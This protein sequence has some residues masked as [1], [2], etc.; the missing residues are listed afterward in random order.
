MTELEARLT[1]IADACRRDD[2]RLGYFA[3]LY[4]VM[5]TYVREGIARGRFDD[6]PRME[7]LACLFAGRYLAALER[8]RAGEATPQSWGV[9]FAAAPRWRPVILQHLLLGMNAHI[10]VDLG[11]AAAEIAD[12]VPGGLPVLRRDFDEINALLGELQ[13]EVQ[14]RIGTVSPWMRVLDFVGGRTEERV[15]NFSMEKARD[16]AWRVA[17]T[18]APLDAPGR[19]R[20]ADGLD[21][22]IAHFARVVEHPGRKITLALLPA[23]LREDQNV[24]HVISALQG[25]RASG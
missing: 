23:R 3:A 9:A 25:P 12:E 5:S 20:E 22:R 19:A 24:A 21:G 16:A 6:G 17:E 11:I 1:N 8:H 10:N 15:I 7:R 14:R 2:D 4:Q 18:Y 13:R